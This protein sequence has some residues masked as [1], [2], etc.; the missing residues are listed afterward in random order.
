VSLNQVVQHVIADLYPLAEAKNIDL[1]VSR[2]EKLMVLDKGAG[3]SHLV[4]NAIDNAIRYTPVGGTVNVSLSSE[5]VYAVFCVEDTGKGIPEQELQHIFEP[6]Y[7]AHDNIQPGNGLGLTISLEV[8]RKLGGHIT[9]LNR[10]EGGV[11]FRYRQLI[12]SS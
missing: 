2:Q 10:S 12:V 1:G 3:L 8:A 4:R 5:G 6:F 7:R 9:L 11:E